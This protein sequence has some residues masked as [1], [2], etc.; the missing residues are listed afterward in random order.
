[1]SSDTLGGGAVSRVIGRAASVA[2]AVIT[3]TTSADA[4]PKEAAAALERALLGREV[5]IL[6]DMPAASA[7]I[8]LYLQKEPEYDAK[9]LTERLSAYGVAYRQGQ[10]ALITKVKVNKKNIEVQ[11]GGGG[12]GTFAD[13]NGVVIAKLDEPSPRQR[14]LERER[15]RTTDPQRKKAIDQELNELREALRRQHEEAFRHARA[16][17]AINQK[18]IAI[19]RLDAGSR[20]NVWYQDKRLEQWVPTAEELMYSLADYL[21]FMPLREGV[22]ARR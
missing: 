8:D 15:S 6:I 11:L 7:G 20:F 17:T 3:V 18:A 2:V 4:Q 5:R 16:L 9:V 21:E 1:M 10:A 19:K 12:Y 22:P 13:D 14:E